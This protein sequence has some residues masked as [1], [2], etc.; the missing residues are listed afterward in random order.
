[1]LISFLGI[2]LTY[3]VNTAS[4]LHGEFGLLVSGIGALS[5]VCLLTHSAITD[6]KESNDPMFYVFTLGTFS[7]VVSFIIALE[8]DGHVKGF[9]SN[10]L[11]NGEPYLKVPYGTMISYWDGVGHYSMYIMMLYAISRGCSYREIGLY[12]AGSIGHSMI[13]FVPG[14]M[15]GQHGLRPSFFLNTPY[16]IFPFI[17]CA[18]I[19]NERPS[20][21]RKQITSS[22]SRLTSRP[23]DILLIIGLVASFCIVLLRGFAVLGCQNGYFVGYLKT[24]EPYLLDSEG[25]SKMQMIVYLFYF[26]PYYVMAIYGLMSPGNSWMPDWAMIH[27]G[28]AAQAQI[29][30]IGGALHARTP[31]DFHIPMDPHVRIVFW[32]IN[33]GLFFIPQLLA[34]RCGEFPSF[35]NSQTAKKTHRQ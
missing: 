22:L 23:M 2:P 31:M 21:P 34:Y 10:Y 9:M 4:T 18:W 29:A 13:V 25:F 11:K 33:L 20:V 28:A 35:F 14:I 12:W 30:H 7:S 3:V 32:V 8:A 19:L 16:M 5:L 6:R 24:Y 17:A 15:A 1:M 27:A 26:A